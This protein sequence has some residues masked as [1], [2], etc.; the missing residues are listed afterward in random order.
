MNQ[1]KMYLYGQCPE[2]S[3]AVRASNDAGRVRL[4]RHPKTGEDSCPGHFAESGFRAGSLGE[5]RRMVALP[6]DARSCTAEAL[7]LIGPA[8]A[9][10]ISIKAGYGLRRV[11]DMLLDLEADGVAER[12]DRRWRLAT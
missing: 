2:C 3:R 6:T 8:F 10:A 7:R 5:A 11:S 12:V 1:S 4:W 9:T